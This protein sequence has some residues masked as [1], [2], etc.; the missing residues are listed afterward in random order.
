MGAWFKVKDYLPN[1]TKYIGRKSSSSP[2]TGIAGVHREEQ[3]LI[4][5]EVFQ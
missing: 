1:E 5:E 2:A 4:L 3:K